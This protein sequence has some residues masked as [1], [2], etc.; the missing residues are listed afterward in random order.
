[1]ETTQP[2]PDR[3]PPP[4]Q[5]PSADQH[6]SPGRTPAAGQPAEPEPGAPSPPPAHPDLPPGWAEAGPQPDP[7]LPRVQVGGPAD[8]LAV[9]PH[10]MG[11]HPRLSFV[12]IGAAGARR[13]IGLGFR[14]DLPDPPGAAAAAEI[15]DHAV[16]VLSQRGTSMVIGIGYGPGRLVT[17]VADAFASAVGRRRL[18][19][20]ELL[21]VEDRRY[22]AYVCANVACCPPEGTDFDYQS[23]PAAA[24]MTV[25][26]LAAYPDR[27]AVAATLAPLTGVAAH[28]PR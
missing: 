3:R 13:R 22:W 6:L 11:F 27:D 16:A 2:S 17:P 25:A 15:A 24:A 9:V 10:L 4:G 19:L 7:A 5:R 8:I 18:A 28:A 1:M 23:H 20:R 12:V 21:R 26:G 14:Y